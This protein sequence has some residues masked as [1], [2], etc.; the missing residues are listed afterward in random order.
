MKKIE[1]SFLYRLLFEIYLD[2]ASARAYLRL[3]QALRQSFLLA[4]IGQE[5]PKRVLNNTFRA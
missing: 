5:E 4:V 1:L 3:F 2:G